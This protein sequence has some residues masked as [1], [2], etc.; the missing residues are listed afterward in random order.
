MPDLSRRNFLKFVSWTL[1]SASSAL[2]LGIL[3]RFLGH[4]TES[5]S[6]T[7]FDIG[8]A[9]DYPPGSR[10]VLPD[11]PAVLQH[12]ESGF[13]AISLICT[14]LGCTL[15]NEKDG[16]LCACHGSR[17]GEFGEVLH[18]PAENPLPKLKVE[19]TADEHLILHIG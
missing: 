11:V 19:L 17:F 2:G 7:M 8:L 3:L 14:H 10:T 16:F 6:P 4:P 9:S 12:T 5:D 13:L 15:K 1:L 18:G